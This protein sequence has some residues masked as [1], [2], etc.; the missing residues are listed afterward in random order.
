MSLEGQDGT[1]MFQWA[2]R[3]DTVVLKES[4]L[5]DV[6]VIMLVGWPHHSLP[7]EAAH[8]V[9]WL[10]SGHSNSRPA[11]IVSCALHSYGLT[12][13]IEAFSAFLYPCRNNI[14]EHP[15]LTSHHTGCPGTRLAVPWAQISVLASPLACLFCPCWHSLSAWHHDF[16]LS[17][18]LQSVPISRPEISMIIAW[19]TLISSDSSSHDHGWM[20]QGTSLSLFQ[21]SS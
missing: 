19:L 4:V 3:F 20:F 15:P 11:H 14:P 18:P 17:K 12:W 9:E 10:T 8:S 5:P 7:F 1:A 6:M 16:P 2:R 21:A 13:R